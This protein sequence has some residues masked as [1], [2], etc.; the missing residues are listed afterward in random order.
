M[1]PSTQENTKSIPRYMNQ[2]IQECV[3]VMKIIKKPAKEEYT[4]AIKISSAG[5]MIIGAIGLA[6]YIIAKISGYIP[7]TGAS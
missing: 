2:K 4:A 6:I 1:E 7:G 5:I 3:R